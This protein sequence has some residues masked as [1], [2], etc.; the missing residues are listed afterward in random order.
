MRE[1]TN[2]KLSRQEQARC[3]D[4]QRLCQSMAERG[5]RQVEL[6][7]DVVQ[8]NIL[9]LVVMFP[10]LAAAAVLFLA[11]NPAGA[12]VE[13]TSGK[14]FLWLVAFFV[15][16]ALHEAIHG[17]TWALMAPRG[18]RAISFGV[19]WRM[20]TPYC[21][22]ADALKRWQYLLGALMPTLILGFG[23]AGLSAVLGSLG[24]F[25][26]AEAMILGGGGD[27]LIVFKLLRYRPRVQGAIYHDHPFECGMVVFEPTGGDVS[28]A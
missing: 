17:L 24:L 25:L 2:R 16:I 13:I 11:V 27:F 22:C 15:L 14:M 7:V 3:Q 20:L 26:L 28:V 12:V 8:A 1:K 4:Y 6:T 18:F 5:Y 9:A 10:F 23:L 19:I 21:T